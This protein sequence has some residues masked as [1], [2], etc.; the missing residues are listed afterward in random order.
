[1]HFS[2]NAPS[3]GG[4]CPFSVKCIRSGALSY[5]HHPVMTV[6]GRFAEMRN[7]STKIVRV[8]DVQTFIYVTLTPYNSLTLQNYSH[9]MESGANFTQSHPKHKK[10]F[11]P[12][13]PTNFLGVDTHCRHFQDSHFCSFFKQ[14]LFLRSPDM[15]L[16]CVHT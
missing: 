1:M 5:I 6:L 14:I 8:M 15:P 10:A 16:S 13:H 3:S 11:P 9:Q 2:A 4:K 12:S 7:F